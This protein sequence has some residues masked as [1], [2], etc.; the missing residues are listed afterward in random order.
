MQIA[1]PSEL[2]IN[3]EIGIGTGSAPALL[4]PVQ[5]I[6]KTLHCY[7]QM[8]RMYTCI[9]R[10]QKPEFTCIAVERVYIHLPAVVLKG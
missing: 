7:G 4:P 9:I 6:V 10:M 3:T 2:R 5:I 8:V 1:P